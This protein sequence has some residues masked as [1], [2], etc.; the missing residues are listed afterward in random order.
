MVGLVAEEPA[1]LP[2]VSVSAVAVSGI[3]VTAWN[4]EVTVAAA[5]EP[6]I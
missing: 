4:Q 6:T 3:Q 2:L 5:A 1:G